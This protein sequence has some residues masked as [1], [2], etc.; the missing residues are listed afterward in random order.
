MERLI[1][2]LIITMIISQTLTAQVKFLLD[3]NARTD[4]YTVSMMPERTWTSPNNLTATGQVTLKATTG[5]FFV[6]EVKSLTPNSTWIPSGRVNTPME[7]PKHDY[8]F[9]R[10]ITEGLA[11]LTYKAFT[12]TKL[13]SFTLESNCAREVSLVSNYEDAFL[14][15]NSRSINIGNSIGAFGA[16]GEAYMGN[17]SDIPI[18]CPYAASL[19]NVTD[20]EGENNN[21]ASLLTKEEILLV[22]KVLY[23]NPTINE[24]NIKLNWL[25]TNGKKTILAYNN[26]G[27]LVRFFNQD[28]QNGS[29]EFTMDISELTNGVYNFILVEEGKNLTL[30][31]VIKV[32]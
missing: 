16:F 24:V 10:L 1:K 11:E 8:I 13:F 30:G 14:P 15:P 26:A 12:P 23:P 5:Q 25:G 19:P 17:I 29:N 32:Q 6:K 21:A 3:Y 18:M 22:N 31:Q 20:S 28:L 7:S 27:E 4:E 2:A 9:F